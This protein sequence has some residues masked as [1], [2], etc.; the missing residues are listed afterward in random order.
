VIQARCKC[1]QRIDAGDLTPEN[2]QKFQAAQIV[3]S[4]ESVI[5]FGR[6]LPELQN[7]NFDLQAHQKE[8]KPD[9]RCPK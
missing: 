1:Y 5:G 3:K 7:Q 9:C 2:I 8:L 6:T 4:V